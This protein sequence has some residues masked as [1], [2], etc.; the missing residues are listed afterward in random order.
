MEIHVGWHRSVS[1][2]MRSGPKGESRLS[3]S[4]RWN[5]CPARLRRVTREDS[6]SSWPI[7]R[8][9]THPTM[10]LF[11]PRRLNSHISIRNRLS[12]F[13]AKSITRRVRR[14]CSRAG[15]IIQSTRR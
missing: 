11:H 15:R 10:K 14:D 6:S 13:L 3:R 5:T 1:P 12:W 7:R 8:R 4:C 2:R 9:V